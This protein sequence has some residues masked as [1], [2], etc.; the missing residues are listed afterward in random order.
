MKDKYIFGLG[1]KETQDHLLGERVTKDSAEKFLE[2]GKVES[3][4]EQKKL[5]GI[6]TSMTYDA[7]YRVRSKSKQKVM[8]K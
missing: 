5:L 6:K 8:E 7:I 2:P 3:K 1:I 4:I